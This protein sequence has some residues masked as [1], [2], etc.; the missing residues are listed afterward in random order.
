MMKTVTGILTMVAALAAVVGLPLVGPFLRGDQ[1]SMYT[2]FP[3]LTRYVEHAGFSWTAFI[4]LGVFLAITAGPLLLQGLVVRGGI[5]NRNPP[6]GRFPWWGYAGL[7]LVLAAWVLAWTRFDWFASLQKHTFAPLWIAYIIIINALTLRRTGTCMLTGRPLQFAALFVLSGVFW[8]YFEYLN[9]FVQ[10]WYYVNVAGF[11]PFEYFLFATI[12]FCTVLPAVLGTFE[13]LR[14]FEGFGRGW[15]DGAFLNLE[16]PRR[17]AAVTLIFLGGGLAAIG[18]WPDYL[19]PLLWISPLAVM[20]S[21]RA[22]AGRRTIFY[23]LRLGRWRTVCLL[24]LS[25]L[26]CGGFWEM[27]NYYSY[28]RWVYAVP[29][30]QAFHIF[31]MPLLGYAGYLPFGL[32]CAVI[33]E[34]AGWHA[35][36]EER[37]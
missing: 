1:L 36:R 14:S 34:F 32:E 12:P 4:L 3:P 27:W 11:T 29:F 23:E 20:T 18:I 21:L 22:M 26:I 28:A 31:E 24:A 25:A 5:M 8:W 19:F 2:E 13:Y 35:H 9:R 15:D 7:L 16:H 10:N 6:A 17:V 30:V 37:P 33:A